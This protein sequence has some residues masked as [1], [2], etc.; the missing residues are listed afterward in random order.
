MIFQLYQK[1]FFPRD[2]LAMTFMHGNAVRVSN[3]KMRAI[4]CLHGQ[5]PNEWMRVFF[6]LPRRVLCLIWAVSRR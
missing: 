6:R 3:S 2:F 5:R 4:F 1:V